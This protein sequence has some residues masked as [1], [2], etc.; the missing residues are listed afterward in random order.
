MEAETMNRAET[1]NQLI[2]KSIYKMFI[3]ALIWIID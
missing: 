1:M 2:E 3:Y